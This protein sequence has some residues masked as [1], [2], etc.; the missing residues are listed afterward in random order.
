MILLQRTCFLDGDCD[1]FRKN[2]KTKKPLVPSFPYPS[3][4]HC[5][6]ILSEITTYHDFA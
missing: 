4:L 5:T 2:K 6:Y 3:S 1:Y